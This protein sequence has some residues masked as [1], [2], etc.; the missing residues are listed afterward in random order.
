MNKEKFYKKQKRILKT[1]KFAYLDKRKIIAGEKHHGSKLLVFL[2]I[3]L[4]ISSPCLAL[5][6]GGVKVIWNS[7]AIAWLATIILIFIVICC[8]IGLYYQ[9]EAQFIG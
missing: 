5:F 9:H 3:G 8:A 7:S 1:E 4:V 6:Y 2:I